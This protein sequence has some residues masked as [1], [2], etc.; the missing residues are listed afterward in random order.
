MTQPDPRAPQGGFTTDFFGNDGIDMVPDNL[1]TDRVA[2][3]ISGLQTD[4]INPTGQSLGAAELQSM[5][6]IRTVNEPN[7]GSTAGV[8]IHGGQFL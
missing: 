6:A 7:S 8:D 1:I 2:A 5:M 4:R 3:Q